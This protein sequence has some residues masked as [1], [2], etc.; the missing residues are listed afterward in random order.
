MR[1]SKYIPSDFIGCFEKCSELLA[2]GNFVLFSGTPCQIYGL[3]HYLG[4]YKIS[5]ENL[6]TV[7]VICH[8]V[9]KIEFF[10][11]YINNLE[12]IYK[13]QAVS[14]N[15]RAKR[16]PGDLQD[17]QVIFENG[18]RY[19]APSTK[20]DWF[21]SMYNNNNNILRRGCYNC[22]LARKE[23]YADITLGDSWGNEWGMSLIILNSQKSKNMITRLKSEMKL[24]R[25]GI[26]E[27]D[28]PTLFHPT[29]MPSNYEQFWDVYRKEGY[30][31]AQRYAGNNTI[32]AKI[33]FIC[34]TIVNELGLKGLF[35]KL[36]AKF[37]NK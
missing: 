35:K 34:A 18:K 37:R 29:K 26:E 21:Y 7:E 1:G 8:G 11:D 9:A 30:L 24:K 28:Q 23:R 4:K 14:C 20:Y 32:K 10:K 15:F 16:K 31:A 17:M 6:L 12:K 2:D 25:I 3:Y 5:Q 33:R 36:Y 13:S 27:I 19:N 22:K